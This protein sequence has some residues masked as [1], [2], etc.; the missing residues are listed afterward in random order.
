MELDSVYWAVDE[1][2]QSDH[3]CICNKVQSSRLWVLTRQ[4]EASNV[5]G[6]RWTRDTPFWYGSIKQ[7][8]IK[9]SVAEIKLRTG[10]K[11]IDGI[12]DGR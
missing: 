6:N 10:L 1:T 8:G 9:K 11:P 3:P 2:A 5:Q 4:A 12:G 7:T